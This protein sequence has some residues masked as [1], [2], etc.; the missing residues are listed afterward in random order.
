M[1]TPNQNLPLKE[2]SNKSKIVFARHADTAQR[3]DKVPST[4]DMSPAQILSHG[5]QIPHGGQISPQ[6]GS[7]VAIIHEYGAPGRPRKDAPLMLPEGYHRLRRG[8]ADYNPQYGEEF[9]NAYYESGGSITRA[10]QKTHTRFAAIP[11]WV[12]D[13]PEFASAIKEV[14]QIIKDEIHSQ[15]MTRVLNEWEPNSAWKFKYFN[16]HFP[17]Y[18]ETKKS[19]KVSFQ[20]KDTL[21]RPE[22]IIDGEVIKKDT[23]PQDATRPKQLMESPPNPS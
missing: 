14:D 23:G 4:S 2:P 10:C 21:I 11:R 18:S 20:L 7:K 12:Q 1:T 16:K 13:H 3:V 9:I 22:E 6:S 15:F 5:P 8:R 19:V 17:E